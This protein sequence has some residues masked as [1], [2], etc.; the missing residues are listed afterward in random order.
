MRKALSLV[1]AFSVALPAAGVLAADISYKAC[2]GAPTKADQDAAKG[3]FAA[4]RTAYEEGD[5]AKAIQYW[6]DAFE[7]DC[8]ASLLL[9]NLANAY[10]KSGN[11]DAAI[12]SLETYLKRSPTADDAPTIQK[13]LDNMKKQRA[14][15]APRPPVA[16]AKPATSAAPT[17]A[18]AA[19]TTEPTATAS[20]EP[21]PARKLTP[22]IVAGA[23][24]VVAL[25]GTVVY[26]GGKSKIADAEDACGPDRKSCTA[27]AADKGNSGRSQVTTGGVLTVVGL[28]GVGAGVTWYL[29]SKPS[30]KAAIAPVVAPGF[31]GLS[32]AGRF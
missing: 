12:T 1:L 28:A 13:R 9:V 17:A 21:K 23:G 22:L 2:G 25:V 18:T 27:D 3:L 4:G 20:V 5:H 24:G 26:F 11:L 8:T 30:D 7:R 16:S 32:A 19:P 15:A 10:E 29:M 14:A 31:A 6:R